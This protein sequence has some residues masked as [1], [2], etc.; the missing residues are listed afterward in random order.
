VERRAGKASHRR[1]P[2]VAAQR[3]LYVVRHSG[4]QNSRTLLA[5]LAA[6]AVSRPVRLQLTRAQMYSMV[7]HQAATV[8]TIA[9]GAARDGRLTGIRHDSVNPTSTFDDYVEY[10]AMASRHLWGASGGIMTSHRV[11]YVNGAVSVAPAIANT[12]YH[13]T[14]NRVPDTIEL[15]A[16][17]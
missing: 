5:A 2:V 12:I 9:L 14:G 8:Q 13:A 10:A 3:Q 1:K 11:V 4:V 17:A 16:N 15:L 6:K 7:R